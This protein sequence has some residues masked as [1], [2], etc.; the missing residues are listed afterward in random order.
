M[1]EQTKNMLIGVFVIAA[2]VIIVWV[3]LFLKPKTG[4]GKET[5]FVRFS[6]V[7]QINVGTRVLYAG[8]PVGEVIAITPIPNARQ[9]PIS[10]VIGE[11]YFYQLEL[12]V[13]S[14]VQV[15]DT[16]EVTIQTSGLLGEK[17]IEISPK[18][19]P[20]GVAP[21]LIAPN[22]PIYAESVDPL[23]RAMTEI[24]HLATDMRK[25]FNEATCWIQK[26]GDE[27]A[28]AVHSFGNAMNEID[29]AVATVNRENVIQDVKLAIQHFSDTFR[30]M[31]EAIATLEAGEVFTNAACIMK[32]L[33]TASTNINM[34]TT[35]IADGKGTLG[36][37]ITDDNLYLHANAIMSKV[38]TLMNDINNYGLLFYLN[39]TWQ[40]ERLKKMTVLNA[41]NTPEGFKKYF[42]DEVDDINL[43]MSRL[44]M[45]I[46]K[47]QQSPEREEILNNKL[48]KKDFLELL[49]LS[50]E[51][52]DNLRLYNE[53]LME[54]QSCKVDP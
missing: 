51:L 42:E 3:I 39:K 6:N 45:L 20:R 13:D 32:N 8:R 4:D 28:G 41:L 31:R 37:L 52:S 50:E 43:S 25:T 40:R 54:A 5:L 21:K 7:N 19:P 30:E 10:D 44:S 22:Q 15:Y 2:C 23:Q 11:I 38:D 14:S 16:D 48:F 12:K 18:I 1:G 46:E 36:K 47:A 33:K 49:R 17:S 35:D 27:I 24:T 26:H 34:I 53:Q 9:R 29:K